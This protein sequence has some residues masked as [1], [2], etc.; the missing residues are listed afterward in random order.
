M[1][2]LSYTSHVDFIFMW[3]VSVTHPVLLSFLCGEFVLHITCCLDF[4]AGNLWPPPPPFFFFL[5][6]SLRHIPCWLYFYGGSFSYT[7]HAGFIFI[8]GVSLTH[9]MFDLH[10]CGEFVLQIPCFFVVAFFLWCFFQSVAY[11]FYIPCSLH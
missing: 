4:Y 2:S 1:G 3:G 6:T 10:F 9:P 7:S 11:L 5:C 8:G